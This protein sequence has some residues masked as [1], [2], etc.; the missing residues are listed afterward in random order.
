MIRLAGTVTS[1]GVTPTPIAL[2]VLG[3][4]TTGLGNDHKVKVVLWRPL[5]WGTKMRVQNPGEG[6][7]GVIPVSRKSGLLLRRRFAW[8]GAAENDIAFCEPSGTS[9]K[10]MSDGGTTVEPNTL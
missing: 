6:S 9:P 3:G 4:Q 5:T 8:V 2:K 10:S 7:A 1:Y